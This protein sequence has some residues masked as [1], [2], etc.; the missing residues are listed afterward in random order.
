MYS[1]AD[2]PSSTRAAPAKKRKLSE[3]TGSSSFAYESG[4]PTFRDSSSASSSV[5]SSLASA[6]FKSISARSPGVVSR[7]STRAF[8]AAWTARSTSSAL[9]FGTSAITSPVAGFRTSIVSPP[10][11]STHSPPTRFWC[12]DTVVLTCLPPSQDAGVASQSLRDGHRNHGHHYDEKDDAVHLRELLPQSQVPCAP[13]RER[14]L[15]TR[16]ERRADHLVDAECEGEQCACD[17][18]G[19]DDRK[20]HESERLPAVRAEV[21]RCLR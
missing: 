14:V 7:H 12:F 3:Q 20:R 17:H 19:G 10:A 1:P 5:C 15:R 6:S 13:D 8:F 2:L 18:C 11:E 21:H 9:A 16:R 4:L